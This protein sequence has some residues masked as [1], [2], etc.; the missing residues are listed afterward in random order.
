MSDYGDSGQELVFKIQRLRGA[1]DVAL[2]VQQSGDL[3]NW[4]DRPLDS[5]DVVAEDGHDLL[6]LRSPVSASAGSDAF[7]RLQGK[8]IE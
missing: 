3:V 7:F 1:K 6:I 8:V 4:S 5:F 2:T